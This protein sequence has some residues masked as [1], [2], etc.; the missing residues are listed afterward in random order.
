MVSSLFG[1]TMTS[2]KMRVLH[3]LEKSSIHRRLV[4]SGEKL[5]YKNVS[6]YGAGRLSVTGDTTLPTIGIDGDKSIISV[7]DAHKLFRGKKTHDAPQWFV[8]L[9]QQTKQVDGEKGTHILS[10]PDNSFMVI[11][12]YKESFFQWLEGIASNGVMYD[13][14]TSSIIVDSPKWGEDLSEAMMKSSVQSTQVAA[15]YMSP[16]TKQSQKLKNDAK[17]AIQEDFDIP[18]KSLFPSDRDLMKHQKDVVRVIA[19]RGKGIIADDVGSG[20]SSMFINGFFSQV[21]KKVEEGEDFSACFPLVIVTKKSLVEPIARETLAW[22]STARVSVMGSKKKSIS[23][24][25][26]NYSPEEAHVVVCSISILD[27]Y[28]DDIIDLSPKGLVVDESHMIKN[29]AVKRTKAALRLSKWIQDNNDHP[30]VVCVSATPMPNRPQELWA[31]LVATG[32]DSAVMEVAKARESFPKYMKNS[33][34]NPFTFKVTDQTR[35]EMRYCK[36]RPGPFGWEAKG[37][38]HESELREIL[39]QNGFIRRKKSEFIV[40]LPPLHQSFVKCKLSKEDRKKYNVAEQEFKDYLVSLMRGRARKESW[41]SEEL[42]N[43]IQDKLDK[44]DHSEAIMKRTALRQ[45]VGEMKVDSIVEW[46][47]K[48]F[49]GDPSI[50]KNGHNEKLIIFAHHKDVQEKII[51]HPE[52]KQ[53][54]V[55]SIQAGQKNVNEIVDTFQDPNSGIRIIVCYSEAREGL[56]LTASY[57]VLVAEIP[58]SPSWLLQMA[59]RCWSRF[60]QNYPPHE[61]TI[62]Y[63]VSDTEIDNSLM[64]MVREK[65]WLNKSIIDPEV[66][67]Q[68]INEAESEIS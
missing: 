52:L 44:A 13:R 29:T 23:R 20:K 43:A 45:M 50:V 55:V 57:A 4:M 54:G 8:E 6:Y 1:E 25:Q 36:G 62:Y 11:G 60:S 26:K 38:Q 14:D 56:T 59:G 19:W 22:F 51:N 48:F 41:T 12:D 67:T 2:G 35:F 46:V 53:Y 18:S 37:S 66:A 65:G 17:I 16:H 64:N 39:Y 58:W 21:Q 30:Y 68:E 47:H 61:A 42:F 7:L 9:T 34:K 10:L 5:T 63:A 49:D 28:V 31:Q 33:T 40:P 32:M 27:K 15:G 3:Y 24:G